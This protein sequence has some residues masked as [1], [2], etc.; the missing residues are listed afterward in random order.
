MESLLKYPVILASGYLGTL[1]VAWGWIRVAG[2]FGFIDEPGHR[3][4]HEKAVPTAGG[5]ALFAG[6]HLACAAVFL[7][8]WQSFNAILG[9]DWWFSFLPLSFAVTVLGL[10]DDRF[11]LRASVK[12]AGQVLLAGAA[13]AAGYRLQNIL[14]AQLPMWLD[15][16]FTLVWFLALMNSFNLIDGMDGL[17]AGIALIAAIG[18][19][20]SLLFRK[21]PGDV[22]LFVGLAG[23]CLG[24]LRYNYYPARL[25]MGD[26]GSLFIGFTL[27]ALTISTQTKGP[28]IAVMGVPLLALGVPLF[29][30]IMAVWRRT[31]RRVLKTAP[32][33][34][35]IKGVATADADHLHHRLLKKGFSTH[36]VSLLLYG[37]TIM[38]V[39]IG[40]L[41]SIFHNRSLG[42]IGLAIVLASYTIFRHVAWIELRDTGE[43]IVRGLAQPVRR[44]LSLIGYIVADIGI[45]NMAWLIAS[46]LMMAAADVYDLLLL[47]RLWLSE[48]PVFTAVPFIMLIIFKAYSRTWSMAG[49]PEYFG[50]GVAVVGGA[51]S[52]V[53]VDYVLDPRPADLWYIIAQSVLMY[54][55]AVSG[56]VGLR[57][58]FR[59]VPEFMRQVRLKPSNATRRALIWSGGTE[60]TR[61]LRYWTDGNNREDVSFAGIITEDRALKNHCVTGLKVLGIPDDIEIIINR[62]NIDTVYVTETKDSPEQHQL[63]DLAREKGLQVY[64]WHSQEELLTH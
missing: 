15:L 18:I 10:L 62:Y 50:L 42:L 23:T 38:L 52:A 7:V 21:S 3:K 57:V 13:Y 61:F 19:G 31:V 48:A 5:I 6:F 37:A 4:K 26:A 60:L 33:E 14:G 34:N 63:L 56:I 9:I 2:A 55:I 30:T 45:L 11:D 12:L 22:L 46:A 8:H 35:V 40:V 43:M 59:A 16:L 54:S 64:R 44:N 47:K 58:F 24:F 25:F 49:I 17:A 29:D 39:V 41:S 36:Q 53:C 51:V 20:T 1:L 28:A 27:A 32:G